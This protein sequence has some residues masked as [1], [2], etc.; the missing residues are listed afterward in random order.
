MYICLFTQSHIAGSCFTWWYKAW[1]QNSF[2]WRCSTRSQNR[3]WSDALTLCLTTWRAWLSPSSSFS[4][5]NNICNLGGIRNFNFRLHC[6]NVRLSL[7][8]AKFYT[9]SLTY[10]FWGSRSLLYKEWCLLCCNVEHVSHVHV[11]L[12]SISSVKT[13]GIIFPLLHD[14]NFFFNQSL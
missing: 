7:K 11:H 10:R 3:F 6:L 9:E 8:F 2:S 4:G 5:F 12:H 1:L 13:S 14:N